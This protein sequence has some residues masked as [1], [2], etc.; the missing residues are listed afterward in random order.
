MGIQQNGLDRRTKKQLMNKP[1]HH[2]LTVLLIAT[3]VCLFEARP[4]R[5]QAN[6]VVNPPDLVS[7]SAGTNVLLNFDE[8][9]NPVDGQPIPATHAGCRWSSLVE[10]SPSAGITTWNFYIANGGSQGT[11]IFPRPVLINSVR[12]SSGISNVF[13]LSSAGNPDASLTTTGN[14]PQ[15][16]LT[17]WTNPVT[18]LTLRSSTSDQ[19]FDDLRLTTGAGTPTATRFR[20]VIDSEAHQHFGLYYPVTFMFQIPSGSSNLTAQYRYDPADDWSTLDRKTTADFFNGVNAVRFDYPNNNAY[21]SVAFCRNSDAIYVR[22][23]NDQTEVPISFLWI[24]FYYDNRSAAVTTSLDDWDV[25]SSAWDTASRILTNAHVHFTVAI[26]SQ[27]NFDVGRAPDWALIQYWYDQG[28]LEPGGH[29]RTHPCTDSGYQVNGYAWEIAGIREDILARLTLRY[30]YVPA[31][32]LPCGFESTQVRQA[33]ADAHYVADRGA[34][35]YLITFAPWGQ[36]GTYQQAMYTYATF[37]W[38]APGSSTRRDEANATFDATY[39]A[40]GIYHLVDHPWAGLWFDGSYLAQ[41]IAHI[42]NRLDVWYAAFGELYLYHFV[43]EQGLVTVSPLGAT[44]VTLSSF[45]ATAL[46]RTALIQWETSSEL[47]HF[48]FNLYRAEGPELKRMRLNDTLIPAKSPG[49]LVGGSYEFQD[50]GITEGRTYHYWLETVGADGT[51]LHGP[52][53]IT[54]GSSQAPYLPLLLK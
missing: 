48:G 21:I 8:F 51:N 42:S 49:G 40:K 6:E 15:T 25:Q 22:V 28:Y 38:T 7:L 45:D 35:P 36:D 24:P 2:L 39:A 32:M 46:Q 3:L 52:A 1:P 54:P 29:S 27:F 4:A 53:T 16:L 17:E 34:S 11:I 47:D 31:F 13:T 26:V 10:G 5:S 50:T 20:I 18:A 19:V 33:I 44:A 9:T 37:D 23:M 41:H 43:Q 30:P 12:V 14:S